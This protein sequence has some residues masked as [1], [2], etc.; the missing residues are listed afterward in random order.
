M[1]KVNLLKNAKMRSLGR[2]LGPMMG[3]RMMSRV[4]RLILE[5]PK[6]PKVNM[7]VIQPAKILSPS[8]KMRNVR[9]VRKVRG[10]MMVDLATVRRLWFFPGG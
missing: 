8:M 4:K 5:T 3:S 9:C 6:I 2:F 7:K 1:A 10:R